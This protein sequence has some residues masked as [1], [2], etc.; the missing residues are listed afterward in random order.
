MIERCAGLGRG[1][2]D[3]GGEQP[4]LGTEVL[5]DHRL[6]DAHSLR[7]VGDLGGTV[8]SRGE[9]LR[10]GAQD[11]LSPLCRRQPGPS[12]RPA[13]SVAI[14]ARRHLAR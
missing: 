10:R 3:D 14:H 1:A 8:A 9:H 7:H 2:L 13:V 4:G 5:E 12:R 6:G 11:G